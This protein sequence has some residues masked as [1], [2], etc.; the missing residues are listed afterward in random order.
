MSAQK[1][2]F[3]ILGVIQGTKN[4]VEIRKTMDFPF[5]PRMGDTIATTEEEDA[6]VVDNIY[7]SPDEGTVVFFQDM[8][9]S[10]A[11]LKERE[12]QGWKQFDRG[13]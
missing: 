6:L 5:V 11:G 4:D 1:I 7:W 8:E 2:T 12:E 3:A 9:F 10:P 13:Q